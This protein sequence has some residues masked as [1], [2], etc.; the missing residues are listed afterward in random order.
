MAAGYTAD[1]LGSPDTMWHHP[2]GKCDVM[3]RYGGS[4]CIWYRQH[5]IHWM[6]DGWK[7]YNKLEEVKD[8]S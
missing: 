5:P 6:W 4:V 7:F 2:S 1:M 3:I 8:V